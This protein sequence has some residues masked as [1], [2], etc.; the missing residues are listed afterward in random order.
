MDTRDIGDPVV[1]AKKYYEAGLDELVFYDI[2][3]SSDHRNIMIDVVEKVASQIFI[4]FSVGGGLR[5]V[6]DCSR[7]LLAGA[8]KVNLNSAAV[9]D[10]TTDLPGYPMP[11][12]PRRRSYRWMPA[13]FLLRH[14][15]PPV[16]RLSSM[17]VASL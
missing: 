11:S 12:E 5:S 3:A 13:G 8:E 14:L 16:T 1:Q 15:S 17:V 7:V 6:E 2:T 4:P 9:Q 10:P